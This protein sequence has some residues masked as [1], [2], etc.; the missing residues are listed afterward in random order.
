MSK[1]G[2]SQY[3]RRTCGYQEMGLDVVEATEVVCSMG[4]FYFNE[5]LL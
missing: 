1:R 5:E 4:H 2:F 3:Q